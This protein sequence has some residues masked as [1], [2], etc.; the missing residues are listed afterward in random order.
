LKR[1]NIVI[2]ALAM[3]VASLFF[4]SAPMRAVTLPLYA[5]IVIGVLFFARLAPA[6]R[7]APVVDIG[8]WYLLA[9]IVYTVLPLIVYIVLGLQY[10]VLND[11][12]LLALQPSPFE[13][14]RIAWMYVVHL[15][16]FAGAYLAVRSTTL[17]SIPRPE[18]VSQSR[19]AIG[20]IVWVTTALVTT[21]MT[22]RLGPSTYESSIVAIGSLP[23]VVRQ[24]LKLADGIGT[25]AAIVT[26][27]ALLSR[28]RRWRLLIWA[29]PLFHL[30]VAFQ[31]GGSRTG[32]VVA[33]SICTLLYHLMVRPLSTR[34]ALIGGSI[35]V[36]GF[37]ALGSYR[38]YRQLSQTS[39][40][41]IQA[42]GGEFE[43]LFA[44]AIDLDARVRS[45]QVTG[46][47]AE[48]YVSDLVAPIPSQVLPFK[49]V[50]LSEWYASRFYP[51]QLE[52]GSGF[53]FGVI[54]Q[55][56]IGF[57][58]FDLVWRGA[59]LGLLFARLHAYFSRNG[60]RLWVTV[61]YLWAIV[62]CYQSFRS[63]SFALWPM[64]VQQFLPALVLME[65]ARAILV[66]AS[67]RVTSARTSLATAD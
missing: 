52:K 59:L 34:A 40:A 37:L 5:T 16:A 35:A 61:L 63:S 30:L 28:S 54:P 12:R 66:S 19:F 22:Y 44:N 26:A 27:V 2:P 15:G 24:T 57:G 33:L 20:L 14:G 29:W 25:V 49:K 56:I 17:E 8:S 6:G 51:A 67:L 36:I 1:R 45:G 50:D 9:A 39:V 65:C 64:F 21:V 42:D 3:I 11:N 60:Q 32:A 46:V 55:S 38:T 31:T 41:S 43:S 10:T 47:S 13:V 62:F 7:P 23:L 18:P 4:Q 53:A 48:L 58:W